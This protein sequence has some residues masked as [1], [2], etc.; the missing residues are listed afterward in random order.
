MAASRSAGYLDRVKAMGTIIGE[1]LEL[2]EEAYLE[3][4]KKYRGAGDL[5]AAA[6]KP[7]AKAIDAIL[8]TDLQNCAD[9]KED[10]EK[11]NRAFPFKVD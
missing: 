8:G 10:Q 7:V 11:L 2:S 1:E 3:L 6:A 5:V 4:L 9:C